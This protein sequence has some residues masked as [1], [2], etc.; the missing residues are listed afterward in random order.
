MNL[1]VSNLGH[2][3]SDESLWAIFSA[4]GEVHSAEVIRDRTNGSSRGF[5]F[6]NMPVEGE[7]Q[8]AMTKIHGRVINGQQVSVQPSGPQNEIPARP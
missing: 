3:V 2:Q 1:F 4:H 5:A 7:A 8:K 6:V